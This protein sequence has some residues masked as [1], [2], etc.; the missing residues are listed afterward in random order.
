MKDLKI[1]SINC[2]T[3]IE[4]IT[5]ISLSKNLSLSQY[6]IILFNIAGVHDTTD[7][8]T[9]DYWKQQLLSAYNKDRLIIIMLDTNYQLSKHTYGVTYESFFVLPFA[10]K[11]KQ[12]TT[13]T[14]I[15]QCAQKNKPVTDFIKQIKLLFDK[16]F[17]YTA[18]FH[19]NTNDLSTIL[20]N[21]N[22]ESIGFI[23]QEK[24]KC[25][26]LIPQINFQKILHIRYNAFVNPDSE[27]SKKTLNTLQNGFLKALISLYNSTH[28]GNAYEEE[29]V[30]LMDNDSY[31]TNEELEKEETIRQNK[32]KIVEI[33]QANNQ[34]KQ[35]CLQIG[36]LRYL[37]FGHDKPL[38]NAVNYALQILGAESAE[39]KN[40]DANLQI[41][42]LIH[43]SGITIL[44]EDKGHEGYAN[45]DDIN[46]L[47]GNHGAYYDIEC[48]ETED[49]PKAVLFVNSERKNELSLRNKRN[50][51]SDKV[52]KLSKS[53]K[54]PIVWTPNLF[55]IA[56]YVKNTGD[57]EFAKRCLDTIIQSDGGIVDF[58]N[59]PAINISST[60]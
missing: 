8:E 31:K 46:Q 30:W 21:S 43:Y 24:Q 58:P 47:I 29:P 39:Y 51:C 60:N 40:T 53:H 35:D 27:E 19:D 41:D 3:G 13:G 9:L 32:L 37:L 1:A 48:N 50:C 18:I 59:I 49:V 4:K 14:D 12:K 26:L 42:N 20:R 34:L 44:G 55:E 36:Q 22:D 45:N 56:K 11:W 7:I 15:N 25:C 2:D 6:D 10:P 57:S 33:E 23:N 52:I 16:D 5:N 28:Q 17:Y 54:T 38:E